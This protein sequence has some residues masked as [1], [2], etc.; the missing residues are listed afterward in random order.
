MEMVFGNL[1]DSVLHNLLNIVSSKL[2]YYPVQ[3]SAVLPMH[4]IL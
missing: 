2:L 4:K 3:F 1:R